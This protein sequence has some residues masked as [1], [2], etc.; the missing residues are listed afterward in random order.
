[1]KLKYKK[2]NETEFIISLIRAYANNADDLTKI[3]SAVESLQE[4][5]EL[6]AFSATLQQLAIQSK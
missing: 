3:A 5:L 6:P 1:M 4:A 2:I